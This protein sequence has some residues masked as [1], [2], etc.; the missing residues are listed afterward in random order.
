MNQYDLNVQ[1]MMELLNSRQFCSSSKASHMACYQELR[2]FLARNKLE[3]SSD[4]ANQWL[5]LVKVNNCR[6]EYASWWKYIEQL[7]ELISTGIVSDNHLSLNKSFYDKVPGMLRT[8]LDEYLQY[9]QAI[10]SPRS[11][12]LTRIYC[13]RIM[14]FFSEQGLQTVKD[15]TYAELDS[16]YN[17]DLHCST[18]TRYVYLGHARNMLSFFYTKGLC[19]K[20][21]S[22]ILNDKI[23]PYVGSLEVFRPEN[24]DL[25]NVLRDESRD[26]PPDEFLAAI[27]DFI[28][29]LR[30]KGYASTVLHTARHTLNAV[31]LFLDRNELGYVPEITWIWFSEIEPVIGTSWKGWRRIL[32]IFE[33]YSACGDIKPDKRYT[34]KP[35]RLDSYP[36]WC[37]KPIAAFLYQLKREF[38]KDVTAEKYKYS[39][40]RFCT[41]LLEHD[42]DSFEA[43][44]PALLKEFSLTD[45]HE[46]FKGRSTCFSIVRRFLQYLEEQDFI[47]S[48]TLHLGLSTGTAPCVKVVDV[49][50]DE[51]SRTVAQYRKNQ[52]TP[53]ELRNIAMVMV[54][55]KLGLRA[56]DVVNLKF[57]D[58]DWRKLTVSIVQQK[59]QAEIMLPIPNDVGNSLY[60]YIKNGRPETNSEYIFVRHRA[61]YGK[62][63]T[64]ICNKA[65]Y[66]ILPDRE[67]IYHCGFHVT[68]RTFATSIL[69]N[70]A[71]I[72]AVMDSLGH[73]DNTSVMKYLSFD[74]ERMHG[75]PLSLSEC[76]LELK[77]GLV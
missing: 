60:S 65:L 29:V 14:V 8:E 67:K 36:Y 51:E 41:F 25:V 77:G 2:E 6:Q 10:Y 56:S 64:K 59:T 20:G 53:M 5:R 9:C 42:I 70:N 68:R 34:Y 35:D 27:D 38:R 30:S 55:L 4:N 33:Q 61:P 12:E 76:G 31:F 75:C 74:E 49:L 37:R 7:K 43:I 45:Y 54:G 69:K 71:G 15:I 13:S 57:S 44:T 18:N 52:N 32:K 39:C 48:T 1:K 17:T 3:Y 63:T 40:M 58:F 23:Y 19:R 73:H 11:W 47:H 16:F 24:H 22:M 28:D 66:A 26:F 62:L 72:N 50:T 46:T 21:H